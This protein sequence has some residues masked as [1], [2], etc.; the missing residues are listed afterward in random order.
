M[1]CASGEVR[2]RI[3]DA[4]MDVVIERGYE[5]TTVTAIAERAGVDETGFESHF[6]DVADCYTQTYRRNFA[7]FDRLVFGAYEAEETWRDGL[8]ASAYAAAR[9]LRDYTREVQFGVIPA[10]GASDL[11]GAYRDQSFQH[12]VDLIDRGRQEL[13]DP[14]SVDRTVAEVTLGSIYSALVRELN[15]GTGTRSAEEFVPLMMY[16]AVGPYLG[17]DAA[18]EE[19]E[20]P[21]PPE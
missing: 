18:S 9:Y 21:P 1:N 17:E 8:R 19:L 20:M 5:K 16:L 10:L 12:I 13:G 2:E 15:A 7:V 11:V 3:C 14:D 6:A 4:L